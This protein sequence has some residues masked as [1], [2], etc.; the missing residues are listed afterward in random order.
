MPKEETSEFY[1][2]KN[3]KI[4]AN[5]LLDIPLIISIFTSA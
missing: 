1:Q 2:P 4:D 5:E 3:K